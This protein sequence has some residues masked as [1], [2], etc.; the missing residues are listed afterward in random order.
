MR[1]LL[2]R[3]HRPNSRSQS[4]QLFMLNNLGDGSTLSLDFTTGVLDPRLTFTRS[5]NAT[6]INSSGLVQYA[7]SNRIPNSAS[8]SGFTANG[9]TA[10]ADAT[11]PGPVVAPSGTQATKVTVNGGATTV[12]LSRNFGTGAGTSTGMTYSIYLKPSRLNNGSGFRYAIRNETTGLNTYGVDVVWAN[13]PVTVNEVIGAADGDYQLSGPDANGWYRLIL[14]VTNTGLIRPGDNLTVYAGYSGQGTGFFDASG[15]Y[16]VWG[17]QL[18]PGLTAS[19]VYLTGATSTGYF[20]VP[21]FDYDPTALTAR[22]LLIEG[23]TSTLNTWSEDYTN[24]DWAKVGSS[25]STTSVAGPD[26]VSTATRRIVESATTAQHG[27]RRGIATTA[28]QTHT[29]SVFVKPGSYDSFG[30][31]LYWSASY[32]A[33]AEVTSISGNTQTV[34][35]AS[36]VNATLTRTVLSASG[37]YRYALTFTH[38]SAVGAATP[39]FN[40]LVK[41]TAAYAGDGTNYMDVYGFMLETG[42]GASSY[43]PT[44]A[45]TGSRAADTCYMSGISSWFNE[46][47]GTIISK[48]T[49]S[50]LSGDNGGI[51]LSVGTGSSSSNRI[52]IR[53][54]YVDY[55]SSGGTPGLQAEMYPTVTSGAVQ[56]GTAYAANDFAMCSNGGTMRTDST[57]AVPVG[58]NTLKLYS[59]A[60]STSG[61]FVNGWVRS[62]K[63]FPIRLPNA[64]LQALTT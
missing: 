6:F 56:I 50:S 13:S 22:G 58:L 54:G 27:I 1:S 4:E 3:F 44:G 57:G 32:S 10:T 63:Y 49:Y 45:S 11:E 9:V 38:P 25:I 16:W 64:Q 29:V 60:G 14:R 5:S 2:G 35:S 34:T 43:I 37:W 12:N 8:L 19:P 59:D 53:K 28:G 51:E 42:S 24:A 7:F 17:A 61:L 26:N 46:S 15:A 30:F 40:V 18:E 36:G 55:Y 47:S 21:R 52:G 62:F 23:Q 20:D 48:V 41:Q 39:D 31:E 33:K